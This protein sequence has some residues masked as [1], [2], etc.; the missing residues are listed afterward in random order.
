[1]P[2]EV[3]DKQAILDAL[4]EGRARILLGGYWKGHRLQVLAAGGNWTTEY[5]AHMLRGRQKPRP[6]S[7]KQDGVGP[8]LSEL[9]S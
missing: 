1:M 2:H 9:K 7:A 4:I 8:S 3:T 6:R 5:V